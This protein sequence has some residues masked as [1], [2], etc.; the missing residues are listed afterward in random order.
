MSESYYLR[1]RGEVKGPASFPQIVALVRKKRLGRHHE[2]S[3]DGR[4]WI[5]V[6]DMPELAEFWAPDI[7]IKGRAHNSATQDTEMGTAENQTESDEWFYANGKTRLGPVSES[8]LQLLLQTKA[9]SGETLVWC[10]RLED[11]VPAKSLPQFTLA[12]SETPRRKES[13]TSPIDQRT[14]YCTN[15]GA[16]VSQKA[17]VCVKCGV[18]P[19]SEKEF[20]YSCGVAVNK[21][22]VV[23]VQCG[24][25]LTQSEQS[26][27]T[28]YANARNKTTAGI[29]A[30]LLGGL[31]AHKFYHGSWGWG[32]IYLISVLTF[33]PAIV[34]LIEGIGFLTMD[35]G[36]YDVAY[37]IS[38]PSAF[39]W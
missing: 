24:V 34:A 35:Q 9:I 13:S 19:R 1:V 30:L 7:N 5:R 31:G 27:G 11:W 16:T 14:E 18:P 28:P 3:E 25:S 12:L 26:R 37:N 32:I 20:C 17:A 36:K 39:K 21:N 15:C 23:C 33:I 29:L 22:Q 10:Q 6:G 2:I 38:P 4:Y 8:Q